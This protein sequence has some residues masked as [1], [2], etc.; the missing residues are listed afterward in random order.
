ML[1]CVLV[2]KIPSILQGYDGPTSL[3]GNRRRGLATGQGESHCCQ[4]GQGEDLGGNHLVSVVER[5]YHER[6]R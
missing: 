4:G 6:S 3:K 2:S 1:L 5:L